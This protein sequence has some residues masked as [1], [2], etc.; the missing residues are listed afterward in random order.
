M[1]KL[2]DVLPQLDILI[3]ATGRCTCTYLPN[4]F[5][6]VFFSEICSKGVCVG[7]GGG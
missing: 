6:A 7:G 1:V 4:M 2:E 5:N 3:T